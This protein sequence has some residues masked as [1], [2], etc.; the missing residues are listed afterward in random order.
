[1]LF[2]FVI[3][4][5]FLQLTMALIRV[6]SKRQ[7]YMKRCPGDSVKEGGSNRGRGGGG[8]MKKERR[9][10][11]E[12]REEEEEGEEKEEEDPLQDWTW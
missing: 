11:D 5:P 4:E 6:L 3:Y 12:E 2:P 9:R 7:W 10:E 8:R 1:M